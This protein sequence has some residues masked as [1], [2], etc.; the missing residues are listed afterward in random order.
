MLVNTFVYSSSFGHN[1]PHGGTDMAQGSDKTEKRQWNIRVEPQLIDRLNRLAPKAGYT[2]GNE[3]AIEALDLYAEVLVD[4][5]NELRTV[6][7]MTI[8]RQREQL[9][10]KLSQ[11]HESSTRRK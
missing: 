10:A 5:I 11:S 2:S 6:E 7:K 8:Q 9:L 3:F 1:P 4:L